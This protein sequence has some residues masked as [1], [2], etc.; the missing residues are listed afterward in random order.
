[1]MF[2]LAVT[3]PAIAHAD[4]AVPGAT[5]DA[6]VA[7]PAQTS[8][9][10]PADMG[11]QAI[12]AMIGI[13]GGGRS[14]PGGLLVAGH[15][16]YQ[17]SDEDWFDGSASFVFGSGGADCFRDR[18]DS[19]ICDH[20]LADGYA[21][22]LT[23]AARRFLPTIASG[24]FWPF[25]R[26]GVGTSIVRFP[27]DEITGITF[28]LTAGVGLRASITDAIALTAGADLELGLGQFSNGL[29]GEPQLGVNIS[30]GAEFKL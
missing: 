28:F 25:V 11:D 17:L 9:D 14:T 26:A 30:A 6:A 4:D 12:S 19:V 27:D 10:A 2:V 15:F 1:M 29:G 22:K 13:A 21:G 24:T 8:G 16:Y 23:V 3:A 20:G 18:M 7:A 5:P